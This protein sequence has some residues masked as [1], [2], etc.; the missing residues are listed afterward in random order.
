MHSRVFYAVLLL[1]FAIILVT[2]DDSSILS[3]EQL[4]AAKEERKK[5]IQAALTKKHQLPTP[6]KPVFRL[7]H[8]NN[9]L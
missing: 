8:Q 1:A 4:V 7:D 5:A 9:G 6:G 3:A 2:A